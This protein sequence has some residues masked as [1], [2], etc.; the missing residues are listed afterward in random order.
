MKRGLV[1][2]TMSDVNIEEIKTP[3]LIIGAGAAGARAAIEM[4]D[5]GVEPLVVSKRDHGDAHTTWAR[6]GINAALGNLDEEDSWQIHAAD[7][8]DEGHFINDP[9]AVE[10]VTENMPEVAR[11][12]D[13][14]GMDFS[15]T[16]DGEIN[17]RYFGAQS[18]RRTCFA[19]DYTGEALLD[20]LVAKAQD[21][22]IPY[23]DNVYV[24]DLLSNGEEV[25][26]AVAYDMEKEH[27]ILF[28]FDEVVLAAGGHTSV[29]A[30]HSSRDDENTGDGVGLAFDAGAE[31]MD[32]E[33]VQ[34]H[35]TGMVGERYGAD[36][37]GRLVTEAI[38]GEGGRLYNSEGERFMEKYS[39]KQMELDARDVVARAIVSEIREGRGTENGGVYLDIS[40][41]DEDFIKERL[42]RMYERFNDLGVNISE[43]P[44]E[45]A[46]TAHY[47]MGG[48]KF[49]ARTG[50]TAV[51]NLHV[52]GE[53]TAGVHGANRL[54][55]N[56]L[57][58]TV[59][60]GKEVGGYIG[61]SDVSK[62][63][64][65]PKEFE[66]MLEESLEERNELLNSDTGEDPLELASEIRETM[67]EYAGIRRDEESLENGLNKVH[68]LEERADNIKVEGDM[69][70]YEFEVANNIHFMLT[71]AKAT[72]K[73]AIKRE[74]SRGAHYR[75]DH[76]E[77]S[78]EYMKN[79]V[80]RNEDSEMVVED[81]SVGEPSEEVKQAVSEGHELD[82]H[83][84]E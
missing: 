2:S 36:W 25:E 58:E 67:E 69:N 80:V 50:D 33:F 20:T 10:T 45:V 76:T 59:S 34:F 29:Y 11:E 64:D 18:Y 63:S 28:N 9:E 13:E 12:L 17:Q 32:M 81:S 51:D 14:W 22:E 77:K 3:V 57:A 27:Y 75:T 72:F 43:E 53:T 39:P 84:L 47:I 8:L 79:F 4:A 62:P 42:P 24:F 30:R 82:Y 44:M 61:Q 74:E 70:S 55:G 54:G 26:A 46:P 52:L 66:D 7:T 73:S 71:A 6:G 21:M 37:D 23:M 31:L 19:G 41:R 15:R 49:D 56:S 16:P 78:E 38:R 48:V 35:P 68:E 40:H 5:K 60:V 1:N 83:H 65:I